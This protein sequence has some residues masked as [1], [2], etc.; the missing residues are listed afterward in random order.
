M[1]N[2]LAEVHHLNGRSNQNLKAI[3]PQ[4][5]IWALVYN[6]EVPTTSFVIWLVPYLV[7]WIPNQLY[8]IGAI[9]TKSTNSYIYQ[10]S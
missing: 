10:S 3:L 2:T 9:K 7:W 5:A 1:K 8:R 4:F 6:P